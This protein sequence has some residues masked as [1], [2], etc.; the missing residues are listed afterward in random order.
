MVQFERFHDPG[1]VQQRPRQ[2]IH[3]VDRH[4][5][6]AARGDVGQQT[7]ERRPL[8]VAAGEAAVVVAVGRAGPAFMGL[9]L[10]EGLS[11]LAL[12]VEGVELLLQALLGALARVD[13][14]TQRGAG[15]RRQLAVP[16]RVHRA[17]SFPMRKK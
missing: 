17:A 6:D 9:A 5:I 11:R 3:F 10:D 2:P 16:G 15:G 1:E 7:L 8:H 4:A 12:G 14:A 13:G